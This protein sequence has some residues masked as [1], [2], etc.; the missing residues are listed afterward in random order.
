MTEFATLEL[1][2][3]GPVLHVWL[4][5][6][7][8][9]NALDDQVLTELATLFNGLA[10]RYDVT[11]AVLGGRGRSFSS[12]ADRRNPPGEAGTGERERRWRSR[13]GYRACQAIADCEAFTVARLH[14]NVI[15][16]GL[17]LALAC[18]FRVATE[19][20]RLRLPEVALGIPLTW[21]T[22]P[23]LIHEIGAARARE[24]T[25]LTEWCD[26]RRADA[27]GVVHRVVPRDALDAE[28]AAIATNLVDKPEL[29]AHITKTQF[30]AYAGALG[31]ATF[32]ES[33]LRALSMRSAAA[34]EAFGDT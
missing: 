8:V 6:P 18:D 5:R 24:L 14:G 20:A 22:V 1:E 32:A 31:D 17:A 29:A 21:G 19:S 23:R 2:Q 26:A 28:V 25:L 15:G 4:N 7:R 16:G 33:D 10:D 3:H 12:G 27:L 30:R 11:V 13:V 34:S 9:H